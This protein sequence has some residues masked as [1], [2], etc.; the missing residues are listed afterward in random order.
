MVSSTDQLSNTRDVLD[1]ILSAKA[2]EVVI[3]EIHEYLAELGE[4]VRNG[5][6][7]V[8]DFIIYKVR[9]ST[10]SEGADQEVDRALPHAASRQEPRRLPRR[11][12]A[13][14]RAG[15]DEDES[16]GTICQGGRRHSVHLLCAA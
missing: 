5:L 10:A 8:E 12:V 2:T 4:L 7:P 11:Q 14:S 15:R 3:E 13:A 6:K 9:M 16:Q 1:M